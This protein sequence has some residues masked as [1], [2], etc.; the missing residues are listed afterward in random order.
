MFILGN[1]SQIR[2][3]VFELAERYRNI[4][5]PLKSA[6]P[7]KQNFEDTVSED[8]LSDTLRGLTLESP[9][10]PR[11]SRF[12]SRSESAEELLENNLFKKQSRARATA[13]FVKDILL[14]GSKPRSAEPT[15]WEIESR[16]K[17]RFDWEKEY[18]KRL[19]GKKL[20][21]I[22]TFVVT[23][24]TTLP[25][26]TAAVVTF[27]TTTGPVTTTSTVSTFNMSVAAAATLL[28][29]SFVSPPAFGGSLEEEPQTWLDYLFRWQA[30]KSI[31]NE[32]LAKILPLL[33]KK[34]ALDFY[35][36]LDNATRSDLGAFQ[37]AFKARF[38]PSD[39]QKL[40]GLS[41]IWKRTQKPSETVDQI[42]DRNAKDE[43]DV[44]EPLGREFALCVDP[45]IFTAHQTPRD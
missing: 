14:P 6:S 3:Y 22:Q 27:T 20:S 12:L 32:N 5:I 7:P 11:T 24:S 23:T 21:L 9:N 38:Y 35:N 44:P 25:T 33:L 4:P 37:D 36:T 30:Y 42:R 39:V 29:D 15:F 2:T 43:T 19:S 17:R 45:R 18:K 41:E 31:S 26:T 34:S 8:K 1:I 10:E 16:A 40:R 13:K 28:N